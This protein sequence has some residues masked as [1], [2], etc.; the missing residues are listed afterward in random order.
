M[1]FQNRLPFVP[2]CIPFVFASV[3]AFIIEPP[4]TTYV[5]RRGS[6]VTLTCR[7]FGNPRPSVI[8]YHTVN[9]SSTRY[10]DEV[11]QDGFIT[12]RTIKIS[13]VI[14]EDSGNFTCIT[15][16]SFSGVSRETSRVVVQGNDLVLLHFDIS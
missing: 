16:N 8:W 15:A 4:Q 5:V 10:E 2:L 3:G 7:V 1:N 13:Q 6:D 14:E 9:I 11:F 12:R